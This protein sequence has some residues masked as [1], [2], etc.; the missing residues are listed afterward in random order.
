[1][2]QAPDASNCEQRL[3]VS[4]SLGFALHGYCDL[5]E[6]SAVLDSLLSDSASWGSHGM[7]GA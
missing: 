5:Q 4:E 3:A 7:V 1:M 6:Q 2:K